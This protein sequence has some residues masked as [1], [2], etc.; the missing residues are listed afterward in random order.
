MHVLE[1]KVV[2]LIAKAL[3][4]TSFVHVRLRYEMSQSKGLRKKIM[5]AASL[6]GRFLKIKNEESEVYMRTVQPENS[7]HGI[8]YFH[9]FFENTFERIHGVYFK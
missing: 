2:S 6:I 4:G 8:L 7:N 1:L 5:N 3:N 9:N